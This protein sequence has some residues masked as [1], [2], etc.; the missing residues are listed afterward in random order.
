MKNNSKLLKVYIANNFSF[1]LPEIIWEGTS[2]DGTKK[3]LLRFEDKNTVEAV[4]IPA[5][6]RL[7]LC[8]S[9]QVG[10]A[11]GCTFCHTGTMG[12]TRN[13]KAGEVVGQYIAVWMSLVKN[14]D[15]S[16]ITNIVYRKID[17]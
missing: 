10:C 8:I 17:F 16:K 11:I 9:S 5:K 14:D 3:F 13:L 7:T 6:G 2:R 15:S 12:L 4:A 1:S